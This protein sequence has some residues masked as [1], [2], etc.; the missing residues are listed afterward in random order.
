M[1]KIEAKTPNQQKYIDSINK[2]KITFCEG[3]AGTGKTFLAT[4]YGIQGLLSSKYDR[5]VIS[6]PLI[7]SD[8]PTGYLPGTIEEKLKPY[9]RPV[10]D[11]LSQTTKTSELEKMIASKRIDIIPFGYMRGLTFFNSFIILEEC[12]NCSYEQIILALTRFG[13]GSK[14]V[15]SGDSDQSDL[16]QNKSGAFNHIYSKLTGIKGIGT[17]NLDTTDIVREPII[18]TILETLDEETQADIDAQR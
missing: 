2:N 7:Q 3:P 14:M 11:I 15:L 6:R 12:Q 4:L 16:I 8:M 1:I 10:I 17:V 18:R 5:I 9:I 13:K